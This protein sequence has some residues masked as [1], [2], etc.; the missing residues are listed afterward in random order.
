LFSPRVV[1]MQ[2]VSLD[3]PFEF[4][5]VSENMLDQTLLLICDETSFELGSKKKEKRF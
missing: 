3:V 2:K 1:I 4:P 5:V